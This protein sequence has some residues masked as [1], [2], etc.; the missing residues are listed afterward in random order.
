ML[1]V[2]FLV[3]TEARFTKRLGTLFGKFDFP[4][5]AEKVMSKLPFRKPGAQSATPYA[6]PTA[7]KSPSTSSRD[8]HDSPE[9]YVKQEATS[10]TLRCYPKQ[11]RWV[12]TS[13][14]GSNYKQVG[15]TAFWRLFR[16]IQGNNEEKMKINMT[17]PV[18]MQIQPDT[19]S[20]SFSKNDYTMSFFVPFKHQKD[21]PVPSAEDVQLT[22]VQPFCAYVRVYRN[23]SNIR[24]IEDNYKAL[25]KDLQTNGLGD[26]FYTDMIYY[27]GY[28]D[29]KDKNQHN[30]IWLV[31]KRQSPS[32]LPEKEAQSTFGEYLG[33]MVSKLSSIYLVA[34][35][36][37]AKLPFN[38]SRGESPEPSTETSVNRSS[39]AFCG[40]H[41]C[42]HF[43]EVKLNATD[44]TLRCYPE[45][46][47]WVS[48]TVTGEDSKQSS[49]AFW[50]LFR[51]IGGKNAKKMK[52]KMTVPVAMQMQPVPESNSFF[53]DNFTM[54]FFVPF[55]HQKD[56][57]AP[58][59]SSVQLTVFQPFCAY[60]RVF[61]G[62]SDMTMVE[63]EYK[64]LVESLKGDGLS[65]EDYR[66]D[67]I[68]SAG[69]DGPWKWSKRHNEIWLISKKQSPIKGDV[70]TL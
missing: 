20:E 23:R 42:P 67:V 3:S 53:K 40:K 60:V 37:M 21:A 30:E 31:S 57:P 2:V 18:T 24:M 63:E 68:Y 64:K 66:T 38:I 46:Y 12:S 5:T 35:N 19:E 48:T 65:E 13:V 32:P 62:F 61:G 27:A 16:Y 47:R 49:T 43:Y 34:K 8:S 59:E 56:A 36:I 70:E 69:Y 4:S 10:Y 54:S 41:D 6:E 25:V 44:Y 29:P 45:R 50:R 9:F 33:K 15:R 22:D 17:V 1:L 11:Y 52:I 58:S 14:T 26:D 55:K 51:Y 28:N 7:T 39:P